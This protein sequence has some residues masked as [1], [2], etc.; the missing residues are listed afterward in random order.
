MSIASSLIVNQNMINLE[1]RPNRITINQDPRLHPVVLKSGKYRTGHV[2][3]AAGGQFIS[4]C[5]N[6]PVKRPLA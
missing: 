1:V 4:A 3:M 5:A 6:V 2:T